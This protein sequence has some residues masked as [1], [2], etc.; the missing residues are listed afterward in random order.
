MPAESVTPPAPQACQSFSNSPNANN[1]IKPKESKCV[2]EPPAA[3]VAKHP[4]LAA[5]SM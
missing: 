5:A 4:G 3:S 2:S 1:Q